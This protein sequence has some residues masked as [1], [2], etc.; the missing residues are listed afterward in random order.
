M[1]GSEPSSAQDYLDHLLELEAEMGVTSRGGLR[2][3]QAQFLAAYQVS[4]NATAGAKA[5]GVARQRIHRWKTEDPIFATAWQEAERSVY[6][7]V[8][9]E[10]FRRAVE[11]QEVVVR[12]RH[13]NQVA[14]EH[15][16]SDRLLLALCKALDPERF[17]G[18]PAERAPQDE[19][20][21]A[22]MMAVMRDPEALAAMD[23]IADRFI[24]GQQAS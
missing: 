5:A 6:D 8:L 4:F 2:Q 16:P 13:G 22:T 19:P 24:E 9:G 1:P 15:R 23:L 12:D 17:G 21:R 3:R 20:W 11:G 18:R 7:T 14:T 10:I